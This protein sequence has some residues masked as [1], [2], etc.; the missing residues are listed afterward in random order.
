MWIPSHWSERVRWLTVALLAATLALAITPAARAAEAAWPA[1]PITFIVPFPP[2]GNSDNLARIFAERLRVRLGKP[3]VV[4][5]RPGG[6]TSVGTDALARATPD[7]YTLLLGAATAFT[8]LPHLRALPYDPQKDFAFVGGVAD[9]LPIVV[10]RKDLGVTDLAGLIERARAQPGKLSFG[11]AGIA[12]AGHIAGE[13]IQRA[14]QTEMLHVPYKGS[15][16]LIAALQG[17]QIDFF[18]DGVGLALAQDGRAS[19]LA[20]FARQRHPMLPDVPTL[21]EAG[22]TQTLPQSGWALVAPAGTPAPILD[23]LARE[24]AAI[25]AEDDTRE[26]LVRASVVADW[27]PAAD[28]QHNL[29]QALAFYGE[30]IPAVG[31]ASQLPSPR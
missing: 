28:Y 21:A 19:A 4:E 23:R 18:I 13:I 11:S 15:G 2:G 17:G 1:R 7:G 8:V 10:A 31:I 22:V 9:Y 3:I 24:S 20:T 27:I 6:T 14:T 29:A 12:S 30:L 25:L 16:E 5:N 26:R